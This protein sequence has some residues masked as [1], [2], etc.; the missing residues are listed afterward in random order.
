MNRPA[1]PPRSGFGLVLIAIGLFIL[2]DR[3]DIY[4]FGHLISTWWPLIL[5]YVGTHRLITHGHD[6]STGS[7]ILIALGVFF[8]L[9]TLDLFDNDFIHTWWPALLILLGIW[10]ISNAFNRNKQKDVPQDSFSTFEGTDEMLNNS[11]F[12]SGAEI[13][14]M[15]QDFK[16]GKVTVVLGGSKIDL[17]QAILSPG[18]TLDIMVFMGGCELL[19]PY[20]WDL[21]VQAHAILG[22]IEDKRLR[23]S[24]PPG[25]VA[26]ILRITGSAILG[27][28][29]IK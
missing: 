17:R 26:P 12:M 18:A 23:Q 22:G 25:T 27:G 3:L 24:Q 21:D 7:Y 4:D 28:I 16:G 1:L 10:I 14:S 2:L 13:R 11:V 8:L 29:E 5:I 6:R 9:H 19:V 20:E 15:S